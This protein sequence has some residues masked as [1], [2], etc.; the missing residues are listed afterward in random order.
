MSSKK[1]KTNTI[2]TGSYT[3]ILSRGISKKT[4]E[5]MGIKATKYTGKLSGQQLED[6]KLVIFETY[7]NGEP[8]HQK[9]RSLSNKKIMTQRG[10][11]SV[12][13]L[14]GQHTC[15]PNNKFFITITEGEF[16]AA[17]IVESTH[18][19]GKNFEYPAVSV[20]NGAQSAAKDIK[21]NLEWLLRWKY[22]V[23]NFD[24]DEAGKKA[25][26]ECLKLFQPWQVR[27]CLMPLKDA[28]EM[29]LKGR[30]NEIKS[31]L[32]KAKEITPKSIV[33]AR[34]I[35]ERILKKPEM[36]VSWPFPTLT[37]HTYG[38]H[39]K[40]IYTIGAGSGIGKTEFLTTITEHLI[41]QENQKVGGV[42][43]ESDPEEIFRGVIG[44]KLGVRL[45]VP[46]QE[47]NEDLVD[48]TISLYDDKLYLFDA[49]QDGVQ[50]STWEGVKS[51]ITYM[52][53][54]LGIKYIILD[55]LTA[56]ACHMQEERKGLD[57]LMAELG[58]LVKSLD[59]TLF[60]VSHL[61]APPS[62][63]AT[64]E[65]GRPVTA[66]AFR[67]SQSI[68]YWSAIMLG[69]ERNKLA[70]DAEERNIMKVRVLKDRF[71]GS[72]DGLVLPLRYDN[73]NGGFS[74]IDPSEGEI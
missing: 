4:C 71:T 3:D 62:G 59:F 48:K 36:G 12:T 70:E 22:V 28:N 43:L 41:L 63:E 8:V 11:T 65:E 39:P 74:E 55:H 5:K 16:D 66:R 32:W 7:S 69:L 60:L 1:P 64:Y 57:K 56:L 34:D 26:K 38:I 20:R 53:Q 61:S 37:K 31:L 40:K 73:I 29:L 33:Q 17:T 49:S 72:A 9:I 30:G 54:G 13:E 24:N 19:P 44:L 18:V 25:I 35:R 58:S 42:F 51:K 27:V 47:W 67:G 15:I 46:G 14:F 21:A 10:D 23:L 2:D 68:Q 52:V 6:E 45:N 50:G